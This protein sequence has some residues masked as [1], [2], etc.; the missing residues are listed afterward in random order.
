[1]RI[2]LTPRKENTMDRGLIVGAIAFA[3]AFAA[4]RLYASMEPDLKRYEAMRE[5]SGQPPILKE[6]WST[7]FGSAIGEHEATRKARRHL[8]RLNEGRLALRADPKHVTSFVTDA[9]FGTLRGFAV[10][11]VG[12]V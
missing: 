3:A 8:G 11:L 5:M 4:E 9:G 7:I 12:D 1:M 6:L 2:R 10:G